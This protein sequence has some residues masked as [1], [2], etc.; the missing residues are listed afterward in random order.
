[1]DRICGVEL[2]G[3][4]A[5]LSIVE[6]NEDNIISVRRTEINRIALR[7]SDDRESVK[8]FKNKINQFFY[9]NEVEK[10]CIKKRGKKG[11]F[12]GGADSFK[13]EAMIQDSNAKEV[14]LVSP[15]KIAAYQKKNNVD[16]P[17]K[18]NKYQ[19]NAYLAALAGSSK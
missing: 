19:H 14:T 8:E 17:E 4:E 15:Q 10:V 16:I 18:I 7:D 1:M 12:S 5:I 2:K 11:E 13:M 9:N 6:R 3:H